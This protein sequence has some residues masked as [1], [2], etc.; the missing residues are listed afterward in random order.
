MFDVGKKLV[1][2]QSGPIILRLS[3]LSKG[4]IG[5]T[6]AYGSALAE[7]ATVCLAEQKHISPTDMKISGKFTKKASIEWSYPTPQALRC[8]NDDE[9][10]TEQGAYGVA[11]LLIEKCGLEVVERSKKKTGFD[12]WLGEKGV[13]TILFQ[14][15]SRLEVS[16]IRHGNNYQVNRR[17]QIKEAQTKPSDGN[18]PA[19]I[20]VVEFS[21]PLARMVERDARR[22]N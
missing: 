15:S 8:W 18:L 14:K 17:V 2:P 9:D 12:Y 1:E 3:S 7:A 21:E 19:V 4:R 5:I 20:V 10:T 16:G 22:D 11:I 6:S 13:D